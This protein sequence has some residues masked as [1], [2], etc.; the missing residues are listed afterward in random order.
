[1]ILSGYGGTLTDYFGEEIASQFVAFAKSMQDPNG[2]FYHPQWSKESID[3]NMTKR[4]RDV[5]NALAIL[6]FFGAAP[7]YD[8]L[9]G[10]K[11]DG[12]VAPVSALTSPLKLGG[13][14]SAVSLVSAESDEIFIPPHLKSQEAFESYLAGL[15]IQKDTKTVSETLY[16]EIPLYIVIDEM[17][18]ADGAGYRITDILAKYLTLYQNN[19]TGLWSYRSNDRYSDIANLAS[20]IKLYDAIGIAVSRYDAILDTVVSA[21]KSLKDPQEISEIT[22][23]WTSFYAVVNNITAYAN[24]SEAENV[25]VL[26]Q[27]F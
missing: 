6:D 16:S 8:T 20:V 2:Y 23:L 15:N 24:E 5:A 26:L 11:G 19:S 18:E 4:T 27:K 9:N 10:V 21:I 17:L 7:T 22:N 13:A 25:K 1:M 3:K 14:R 12:T